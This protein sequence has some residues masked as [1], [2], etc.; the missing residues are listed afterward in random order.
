ME[1]KYMRESRGKRVRGEEKRESGRERRI[2]R[3][4]REI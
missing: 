1:I 3:E 2:E 4:K